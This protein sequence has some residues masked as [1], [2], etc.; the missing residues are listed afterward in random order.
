MKKHTLRILLAVGLLTVSAAGAAGAQTARGSVV[1]RIPFEFHVGDEAMP[2]GRYTI[3]PATNNSSR[4]LSLRSADGRVQKIV[5]T[6]EAGDGGRDARARLDFHRYGG[7][8]F[9]R[10]VVTPS[11]ARALPESEYE[12]ETARENAA[13]RRDLARTRQLVTILLRQK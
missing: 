8:Y 6:D 11:A 3:A 4:A 13:P 1:V 12:R 2:A 9:L 7:R 10:Q 5:L